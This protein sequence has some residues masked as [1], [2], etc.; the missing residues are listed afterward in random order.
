MIDVKEEIRKAIAD[1]QKSS[2]VVLYKA[3]E[4]IAYLESELRECNNELCYRCGAY[5]DRYLGAC[6]GCRWRMD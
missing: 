1:G 6:D 4:R 2:G 3:V 5:V